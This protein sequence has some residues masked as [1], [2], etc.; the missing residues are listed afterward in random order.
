MFPQAEITARL[1]LIHANQIGTVTQ[2]KLIKALGNAVNVFDAGPKQWRLL[3]LT[4]KQIIGL[5]NP[6]QAKVEQ[7]LQ[8]AEQQ[9]CCLLTLNTPG[10]PQR[11]TDLTDPPLVLYVRGDP[12]VLHTPQLAIVGSRTPTPSAQE[13]AVAFAQHLTQSGITVTSGLAD[14]I[15]GAAHRGAIKGAGFT[16]AIV[17]TGLD[18]VYPAKHRDLAYD[19]AENGALV[20]EFPIGVPVR[21][22]NFPR[23]NRLI[24]ALSLGT[25]VVEAATRSGSLITAKQAMELGRE[26]MAMPGSI[27]NPLAR[28]CHKLIRDG[29]KLIETSDDILVE[30]GPHIEYQFCAQNESNSS[31]LSETYESQ[32][33]PDSD[34]QLLD[35]MDFHPQPIDTLS[36]RSGLTAPEVASML[37]RLEL[38]G[39]VKPSGG[40]RY[41][42]LK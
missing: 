7:D 11:L 35:I 31:N 1:Q 29:A 28:G 21:A 19:I 38:Q 23:R 4:E 16:V 33:E 10:Y 5:Q 6:D 39:K 30:I 22:E 13:T 40:S 34:R 15:D 26:V 20:S 2:N 9:N 3:G 41:E 17:G 8:W 27:H 24:A 36:E 12:D 32:T 18:R 42:R 25:L 37:L 14:G